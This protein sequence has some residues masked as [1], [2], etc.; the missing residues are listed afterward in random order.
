MCKP[1]VPIGELDK[2]TNESTLPSPPSRRKGTIRQPAEKTEANSSSPQLLD[3]TRERILR[4]VKRGVKFR[5]V[6]YVFGLSVADIDQIVREE[7]LRTDELRRGS[8]ID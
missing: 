1:V 8:D 4:D 5:T 3:Q 2:Q 6:A 7:L